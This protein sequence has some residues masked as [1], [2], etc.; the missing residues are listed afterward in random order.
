MV[1]HHLLC[2]VR[3]VVVL[4]LF[5][6]CTSLEPIR[7]KNSPAV[8]RLVRLDS[9]DPSIRLDLRYATRNNFTAKR[10]YPVAAAWMVSDAAQALRRVQ[11]ELETKG[12]GL[13]VFDAYRPYHVQQ[14]MW[15]LIRDE[16]YVSN[17][18][19][20]AGRHTRGTAV[21]VTLV[22]VHGH[23]LIMP[24]GFDDFSER[25]H[26]DAVGIPARARRNSQILEAAMIR[27]GFEPY[28]YE[29]WHFDYRGWKRFPPLDVSL[30]ELQ[31]LPA[32][33]GR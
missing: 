3:S 4:S 13:K 2:F 27:Q 15:D 33:A 20:N 25:A 7:T 23:E 30:A 19:K 5:G 18:A 6:G 29:W 14:R 16:R 1:P 26:R 31:T 12:L 32:H 11:D 8:R 22:D 28:P 17:P 24:T 9:I 10:L 21:D